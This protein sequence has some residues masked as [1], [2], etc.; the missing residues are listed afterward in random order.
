[1]QQ[2]H[3][4]ALVACITVYAG[5]VFGAVTY[6]APN[7][8]S[9]VI[10]GSLPGEVSVSPSGA[11]TYGFELAA[12]P[13]T[14][15]VTPKLSI[16]YGS[17]AGNG[18]LGVGW[19]LGGVP[20]ITR[21]A[22]RV[23]S[24]GVARS[25]ALT[26]DDEY[27]YEGQRLVLIG[28]TRHG[29]ANY[30]LERDD[31]TWIKSFQGSSTLADGPEYW[32]V[33]DRSG[34][35]RLFGSTSSSRIEAQGR[36]AVLAWAMSRLEDRRGNY[37][38]FEYVENNAA[39]EFYLDKVRYTGNDRASPVQT[40]YHALRLVYEARPDLYEGF[41]AGARVQRTKRLKAVQAWVNTAADGTAG[42]LGREWRLGYLRDT[43]SGRS[44]LNS[45]MDCGGDGTCLPATQFSYSK[46][47]AAAK[48]FNASGSGN[49]G[50]PAV[51]FQSQDIHGDRSQQLKTQVSMGDFNGDGRTDLIRGDGTANWKVCLS[52]GTAFTCSTWTGPAS[53]TKD[54]TFGD[55]NGDGRTDLAWYPKVDGAGVWKVCLSTG[56]AFSC[57]DWL[58]A[59]VVTVYK[60]G[61]HY[62]HSVGDFDGDGR[63]D[64]LVASVNGSQ[65]LCKSAG[66]SFVDN[67]CQAFPGARSFLYYAVDMTEEDRVAF[68]RSQQSGDLDGDGRTDM[69][70]MQGWRTDPAIYPPAKLS[71]IRA[72]DAAFSSFGVAS[73]GRLLLDRSSMPGESRFVD[74]NQDPLG[75]YGDVVTGFTQVDG[76]GSFI[77]EVCRSNG[78]T[79]LP[80]QQLAGVTASTFDVTAVADFDGDGVPD[81]KVSGGICRFNPS[82]VTPGGFDYACDT[83][84]TGAP[85]PTGY[86]DFFSGDFNGDGV[87]DSADYIRT[88]DSTGYWNVQLTGHVG[89]SGLLSE[90]KNGFGK[91]TRIE[92]GGLHEG[93][94]YTPG[95]A[96]TYPVRNLL[97]GPPVVKL[98]RRDNGLGGWLDTTYSYTAL[99]KDARGRPLGFATVAEKSL[100]S[101]VTTTTTYS[102][103]HVNWATVGTPVRIRSTHSNGTVLSDTVN[104]LK[105]IQTASS[106]Q[107]W[108]PY[109]QRSVTTTKDLGGEL[110][111]TKTVAV[112]ATPD[113]T[114]GIDDY[115]NTLSSTTTVVDGNG[116]TFVT[117][118][119]SEFRNDAARALYGL[120]TRVTVTNS[121]PGVPDLSR[122]STRS[123]DTVTGQLLTETTEPDAQAFTLTTTYTRHATY[124]VVTKKSLQWW[125][126]VAQAARTRDVE[127]VTA[128]DARYRWPLQVKNAKGHLVNRTYDDRS[129]HVLSQTDPNG[130]TSRWAFDTWGRTLSES[131]PDSTKRTWA[132][133]TCIN[134]CA[135]GATSVVITEDWARV[136]NADERTVLP[137]EDF[138]DRLGRK[139]LSRT[140]NTKGNTIYTDRVY[141]ALG[142]LDKVSKPHLGAERSP[143]Q[144][145]WTRLQ[146]D[147]LARFV[148]V[149]RPNADGTGVDVDIIT[150][151]GLSVVHT[152]PQRQGLSQPQKRTDLSNGMGKLKKVTDAAG[153]STEYG[154]DAFGQL[155][156]VKDPLGNVIRVTYDRLGRKTQLKDPNLGTWTYGV[157]PLGQTYTQTD[158]LNQTTT[159]VYDELGRLVSRVEPDLQ[160][161]W[162]YDTA[163]RGAD[164]AWLG[165]LAEAYTGPADAKTYRRVHTYDAKGREQSVKTTYPTDW[166]YTVSRGF[167]AYGQ[168]TSETHRRDPVGLTSG[169]SVTFSLTYD[170]EG[171]IVE[172]GRTG[173]TTPLWTLISQNAARQTT[174][175]DFTSAGLRT[176]RG[177]NPFTDRQTRIQT[178]RAG[179]TPGTLLSAGVQDDDYTYDE[180]GNLVT[181]VQLGTGSSRF[182]EMFTYDELDRVRTA[183]IGTT[184]ADFSYDA[185]GNLTAKTGVG[186][187]T[188]PSPGANSVR[189]HAVS[190]IAGSVMGLTNPNFSYDANGNLLRGLNRAYGWTTANL[191]NRIDK[192]Q[193]NAAVERTEFVYGPDR[194][195][196]QQLVR[197]V[198]GGVAG[199]PT[200]VIRY[201]GAI[202]K[203]I[204]Y[205]AGTT[206][207]RTQMPLGLGWYEEVADDTAND[208]TQAPARTAERYSHGDRLGSL[209]AVTGADGNLLQRFSYDAW[210]R[211]RRL[212]GSDDSW[213]WN[214]NG[215]FGDKA[216]WNNYGHDGYT[217]QE[218]I[219][220]LGLVHLNGR[221]YDPI[222]GRMTSADP[223]IPDPTNLQAFNR[224]SY[225]LNN[226]LAFVDPS[227]FSGS[228]VEQESKVTLSN[229]APEE[230]KASSA[231]FG[232][233][234]NRPM[235]CDGVIRYGDE[236]PQGS[237][238]AAKGASPADAAI[239]RYQQC[240]SDSGCIATARTE[241]LGVREEMRAAGVPLQERLGIN[242]NI[243]QASVLLGEHG[244]ALDAT[245][246]VGIVAQ[247][248]RAGDAKA[249]KA[250]NLPAWRRV[251]IDMD[252]I[253]SGHMAGGSRVSSLKTLFSERLSTSQIEKAVRQ[254]YR[255]G[256]RVA[257]QGERVMVRGEYGGTRIEMWVNTQTRTIETAYPIGR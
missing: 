227:G 158:A 3:L 1:M 240:G 167:N 121:A 32:E 208:A 250:L 186:V 111:S 28:G 220:Q 251:S 83:G 30:R 145:V 156:T 135:N 254:A 94:V 82:S 44:F 43:L 206:R 133:R 179:T 192:L 7:L 108:F 231:T 5:A 141:D 47:N 134:T 87:M 95:A 36:S 91:A 49:W 202:E 226:G 180:V 195:R 14:A 9:T 239:Q 65:Y 72:G 200:R 92:Y 204:D 194:Q 157:D 222:S 97:S 182:T 24:D 118:T 130:L 42:S 128:W 238:D 127:T 166:D 137:R 26:Q 122:T 159:F 41:V 210:G 6:E 129:G 21:C 80:C 70:Q 12:P 256:E 146:S 79:L 175:E 244:A 25:V 201:A 183:R 61:Q 56:S 242:A 189:P 67:A 78:L 149:E 4:R 132:Y 77:T 93:D 233:V 119:V 125:D 55:F 140:W 255:Y 45:V 120:P 107:T 71:G 214:A 154:Y 50:G 249:T 106:V 160:S 197:P 193:G 176:L 75:G 173:K 142:R 152:R 230:Q 181:R 73:T 62:G 215:G 169:R 235:P 59:G 31:Y 232:S 102:Q 218:Q 185:A 248:N 212:G 58:G 66:T 88:S 29:T 8:K 209:V 63:D 246:A 23:V 213:D 253:A 164:Q 225:V 172:V 136:G 68:Q 174:E 15:G 217:G 101:G 143:D 34:M 219:D 196:L 211:R 103:D 223:T 51:Q 237:A 184:V 109:V 86:V 18:Y 98:V 131:R 139:V 151:T 64:I 10:A 178:G 37:A 19:R 104:T 117:R 241:M 224:Y 198:S 228:P 76:D 247:T 155:L 116:E 147:D 20:Q 252:H 161:A 234:C 245:A 27:C 229:P 163:P 168:M 113:D 53:L 205:T 114:D 48:V 16:S 203:E 191:P 190:G 144:R 39:G 100:V 57:S 112:T 11:A 33:R 105:T 207:I 162:V 148:R 22:K 40:T 89:Y 69:V 60:N 99:R 138:Q 199:S 84:W 150:Y 38:A 257:T 54:A 85:P 171:Q 46:P 2:W 165:L 81:A 90:V 188:Y 17:Q 170:N 177:Y 187:Y 52:T 123:Y 115:G 124:G 216:L 243:A 96:T 110:V 221:V 153:Q 13:G 236:S 126:P 35:V 74:L